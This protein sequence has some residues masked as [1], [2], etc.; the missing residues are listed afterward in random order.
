MEKNF[1]I[2]KIIFS[3]FAL[4]FSMTAVA[5]WTS[6]QIKSILI[7]KNNILMFDS[8][9]K[10]QPPNCQTVANQWAVDLS[11]SSGKAIYALL[12]SAQVQDKEVVVV[13]QNS[14]AVWPDRETVD[15][16]WIN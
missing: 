16:L 5:G 11:T 4:F 7:T 1:L 2:A 13:G 10:N 3:T 9:I 15:Y 12:L 6:G 14:C 8:G